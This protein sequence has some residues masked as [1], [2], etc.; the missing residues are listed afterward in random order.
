MTIANFDI[1]AT[2]KNAVETQLNKYNKR[3]RK[4]AMDAL[5]W[6]WGKA[7]TKNV[8]RVVNDGM[9]PFT[10]KEDVLFLPLQ[11]TGQLDVAFAG[12]TFVAALQHIKSGE[13]IVRA[14]QNNFVTPVIYKNSG[15]ACEHCNVKRYRKE[16]YLL[17]HENGDL[18]Q[19]GSTCIKDFIG[20]NT[21]ESLLK[22]ATLVSEILWYLGGSIGF[23]G[24][25]ETVF[26]IV[27]FLAKTNCVI[28]AVGWVSKKEAAENYK[29]S[30]AAV[31]LT[32][33][34]NNTILNVSKSD[35]IKAQEASDWAEN[36]SDEECDKSDYLHN[37]RSIVRSGLVGLNTAG[38][39]ASIVTAYNKFLKKNKPVSMK[40]SEYVG[41][42][43][44]RKDFNLLLK[45]KYPVFGPWGVSM[46][47]TFLDD[48]S[49]VLVWYS[50][51]GESHGNP[52]GDIGLDV[53]TSY[54]IRG[55]I[56][57]HS[58]YKEIKQTTLTRCL[59]VK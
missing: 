42:I 38:F 21:P 45:Q 31:V 35:W 24:K 22:K 7:V 56:K 46:L 15:S 34:H 12:W 20:Q 23:I 14:T 55:T 25:D 48:D 30:T 43:G 36:L 9:N 26:P 28:N 1:P 39:A 16:T 18:V 6:Q 8:D 40:V 19:V 29:T 49:N 4:V 54:I 32:S 52:T 2:K 33:Y 50:S 53:G 11:V 51:T 44:A 27:D 47:H 17:Q 10:V 41:T 5:T 37:I 57:K 58:L 3:A 59:K 13:N